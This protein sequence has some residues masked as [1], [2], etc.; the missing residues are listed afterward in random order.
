MKDLLGFQVVDN[1]NDIHPDMDASFCIY[2]LEDALAMFKSD[3]VRWRILPI[4]DGDVEEPTLM[5]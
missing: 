3:K 1:N 4:Y 2:S 5:F